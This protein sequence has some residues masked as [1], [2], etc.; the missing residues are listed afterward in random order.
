MKVHW[1]RATVLL[2]GVVLLTVAAWLLVHVAERGLYATFALA[3]TAVAVV[4][5]SASSSVA[6]HVRPFEASRRP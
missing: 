2:A 6:R 4:A 3:A 5:L 1:G